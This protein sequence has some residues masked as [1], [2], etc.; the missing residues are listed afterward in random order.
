MIP[1]SKVLSGLIPGLMKPKPV[2]AQ[3]QTQIQKQD[4][5][6]SQAQN[7]EVKI[8][9]NVTEYKPEEK[10]ND[11]VLNE[12]KNTCNYQQCVI[13]VYDK[14]TELM[15]EYDA[16]DEMIISETDLKFI[17]KNMSGCDDVDIQ[18]EDGGCLGICT[19]DIDKIHLI[20]GNELYNMKYSS[21]TLINFLKNKRKS[22]KK[23]R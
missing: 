10:N 11:G 6:Q 16:R 12:L 20:Y 19:R 14:I 3:S 2:Q 13:E 1:S 21:E 7:V 23:V 8:F 22:W 15:K 4:Q 9:P 17:I 18:Y 5:N